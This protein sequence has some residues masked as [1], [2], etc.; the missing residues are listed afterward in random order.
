[1]AKTEVD[2]FNGGNNVSGDC[3]QVSEVENDDH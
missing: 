1:M 3:M 2:D